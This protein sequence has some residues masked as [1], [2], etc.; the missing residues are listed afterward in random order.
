MPG[1]LPV[2]LRKRGAKLPIGSARE[3]LA[4][5]SV[6]VERDA[7]DEDDADLQDWCSGPRSLPIREEV[8]GLG[9]WPGGERSGPIWLKTRLG[10][11]A[12]VRLVDE[13]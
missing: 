12:D 4:R 3:R 10:F 6:A 5:D 9:R 2:I 13:M 7:R 11:F 8:I 1:S